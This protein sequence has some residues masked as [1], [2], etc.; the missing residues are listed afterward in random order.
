MILVGCGNR[1]IWSC[2]NNAGDK[3]EIVII[4]EDYFKGLSP[5]MVIDSLRRN[6]NKIFI[7]KGVDVNMCNDFYIRELEGLG[8]EL[9]LDDSANIHSIYES[10]VFRYKQSHVA[11]EVE[12]LIKILKTHCNLHE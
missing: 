5:A 10:R 9:K 4:D 2:G 12:K 1:K 7:V 11:S 6:S 3:H 8:L